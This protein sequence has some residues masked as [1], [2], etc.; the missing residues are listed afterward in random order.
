MISKEK[1]IFNEK[2]LSYELEYKTRKQKLTFWGIIAAAG[3][4][5]F[6]ISFYI[7]SSV[8]MFK[9]PK[10]KVLSITNMNLLSQIEL[11]NQQLMADNSRLSEIQRR[12][13]IVYRPIFGMDEISADTR[14]AGFGGVDRYEKYSV[15]DHGEM[16]A[17]VARN[18]DVLTK[19]AY[20][21]SRSFDDVELL[22]KRAGSMASSVPSITPLAP[23]ARNHIT[24]SFGYRLHPI[25]R[26]VIFHEGIDFSGQAGEPIYVTGD[27]VVEKVSYSFFG[28]GVCIV[29]DHGFGYKTRY[30]HLKTTLV[31]EGQNVTKGDQIATMGNTG[32]S[33][34][35][36]LHYEVIYMGR[37][38]NPWNF[39][40]KNLSLEEYME[41]V[42]PVGK[43]G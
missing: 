14:N 6:F 41:L 11:L 27:G 4:C 7:Y 38:I 34:G 31:K 42:K 32:Q 1:Y 25:Q 8:L 39:L 36:H 10:E 33:T 17:T 16:M 20:I 37:Q 24:S 43:K 30:A 23:I 12:D 5:F 19:K 28:Y 15:F 3:V 21:Q 40:S 22:A 13:N 18:M 9:T 29:V 2:T 26:R 35:N